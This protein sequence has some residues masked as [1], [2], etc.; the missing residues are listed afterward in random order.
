MK[1]IFTLMVLMFVGTMA[2]AQVKDPVK[3]TYTAK[4]MGSNT[5]EIILTASLPK[6]WHIYS[7]TTGDGGPL[8]TKVTIKRNPLVSVVGKVK[9]VGKLESEYD[10]NFETTVKYYSNKVEFIQTVVVRGK[11]KTNI[12]GTVEYMTCD[13][14]RCLPPTTKTFELKLI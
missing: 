4:K 12:T 6:P 11:A 10:K 3:W 13:D 5:Y 8:P 7:T 1:K 9:E 14:E 2:I